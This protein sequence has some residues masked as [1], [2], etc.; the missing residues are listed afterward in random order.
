[1]HLLRDRTIS[2]L[3]MARWSSSY[4]RNFSIISS[5]CSLRSSTRAILARL[6]S[7]ASEE[8]TTCNSSKGCILIVLPS[9]PSSHNMP[10]KCTASPTPTSFPVPSFHQGIWQ[11]AGQPWRRTPISLIVRSKAAPSR[12]SLLTKMMRGIW[13]WLAC[14][15]TCSV[16]ASTPATPSRIH[17]APSKMRRDRRTSKVKSA[18]PGVSMRLMLCDIEDLGNV[19]LPPEC[20][21]AS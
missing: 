8:L 1:M 12:S 15:Q 9:P 10:L 20:A 3:G 19:N 17:T 21:D 6:S 13:Y 2:R 7:A 11:T 4:S 16:C 14:F 18:W 5:S